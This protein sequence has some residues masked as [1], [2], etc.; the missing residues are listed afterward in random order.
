[1]QILDHSLTIMPL[2]SRA[3]E[4]PD[5]SIQQLP[6][7]GSHLVRV[8]IVLPGNLSCSPLLTSSFQSHFRLKCRTMIPALPRHKHS[9]SRAYRLHLREC[10]TNGVQRSKPA[11]YLQHPERENRCA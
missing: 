5:S 7:P 1:M 4:H 11:E 8:N 10:P 2:I 9:L 3:L 6:F